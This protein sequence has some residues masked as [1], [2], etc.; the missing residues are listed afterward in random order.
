MNNGQ[1][2]KADIVAST[3]TEAAGVIALTEDNRVI[4]A[5]QFRCG[6]EKIMH[7]MPGGAVDPGETPEQAIRR[8]L[9]EEVGY[10]TDELEYLGGAYV[11]AWEDMFHHYF[12][13]YNCRF[14][15]SSNPEEFEEIE[16]NTISIAEFIANAKTAKMTDAQGV[17]LAY[18]KLIELEGKV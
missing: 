10:E 3:A 12:L 14:T 18:D 16:V 6:P 1:E 2:M 9:L 8:E 4:I 7:E 5:T 11:N 13:A 17:F 15:G